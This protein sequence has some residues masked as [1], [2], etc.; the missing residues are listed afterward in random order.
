MCN[1]VSQIQ[2]QGSVTDSIHTKMCLQER[3]GVEQQHVGP[4]LEGRGGPPIMTTGDA[5]GTF[6][7]ETQQ[8]ITEE[9]QVRCRHSALIS[10]YLT[11]RCKPQH[12]RIWLRGSHCLA[13]EGVLSW[14]YRNTSAEQ[15]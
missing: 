14:S 12:A 2:Y 9:E 5:K 7:K 6:L 11:T 13:F 4:Y 1:I 15:W 3:F 8:W 10:L